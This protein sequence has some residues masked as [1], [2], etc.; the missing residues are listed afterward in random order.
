MTTNANFPL[1]LD[2]NILDH[3]HSVTLLS[4]FVYNDPE[5]KTL[6]YVPARFHS[7]WNSVPRGLWNLMPP[8]EYPE[9]GIVHDWLYQHPGALS[10]AD[11]DDIHRR[12][13]DLCGASWLKRQTI[14]LGIRSGGWKPWGEYRRADADSKD[15]L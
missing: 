6:V 13:M 11:V 12:I 7:D 1:E 10:R 3:G 15:D 14:W 5:K 2:G 4:P 9:A 8:T